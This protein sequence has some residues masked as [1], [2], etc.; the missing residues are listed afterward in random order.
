MAG[1]AR[2][3]EI[4]VRQREGIRSRAFAVARLERS[5]AVVGLLEYLTVRGPDEQRARRD[6]ALAIDRRRA[7]VLDVAAIERVVPRVLARDR[8]GVGDSVGVIDR[9]RVVIADRDLAVRDS[10]LHEVRAAAVD[11]KGD[12]VAR[13]KAHGAAVRLVD[14]LVVGV[15]V[16]GR[17][18]V[19]LCIVLHHVRRAAVVPGEAVRREV[20][21]RD[22]AFEV[23]RA[24]GRLADSRERAAR[25]RVRPGRVFL[26]PDDVA[27]RVDEV[28]VPRVR[29]GELDARELDVMRS[30]AAVRRERAVR[31]LRPVRSLGIVILEAQRHIVRLAAVILLEARHRLVAREQARHRLRRRG[32]RLALID[33][34]ERLAVRETERQ[35][36]R[37]DVAVERDIIQLRR[38][39]ARD[40]VVMRRLR[41][42]QRA[43]RRDR[44]ADADVLVF[45][46]SF[47]I[48]G[49]ECRRLIARNQPRYRGIRSIEQCLHGIR[50]I[51]LAIIDFR[52][53]LARDRVPGDVDLALVDI[54]VVPHEVIAV[55]RCA[56]ECLLAVR[57]HA[58]F[59]IHVRVAQAARVLRD[60]RLIDRE[61][62]RIRIVDI[63]EL[64][65]LIVVRQREIAAVVRAFV[66]PLRIVI[67][68][69]HRALAA[70]Q[71]I[72][73]QREAVAL[74]D[75]PDGVVGAAVADVEVLVCIF[76]KF[77]IL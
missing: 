23:R 1:V 11:G 71:E 4:A 72:A 26:A 28:V 36:R 54:D 66:A 15:L 40:L 19:F 73:Q 35:R 63:A 24:A 5:V 44:L 42:R 48:I 6:L 13:D 50:C 29:A 8:H 46:G 34:R 21:P 38:P 65:I 77:G 22:R 59:A 37:R 43:V 75:A 70:A 14:L 76:L 61:A 41:E 64:H 52:D 3:G 18:V 57:S 39:A 31:V 62:V 45:E 12:A 47:Q 10:R 9:L 7:A 69:R 17:I 56:V 58:I 55:L 32:V 51:H 30:R 67:A 16:D 2:V 33:L 53:M 20:A 27:A 49:I 74:V 25:V 60:L 68:D